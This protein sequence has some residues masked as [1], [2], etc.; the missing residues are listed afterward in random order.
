MEISNKLGL[1]GLNLE[2]CSYQSSDSQATMAGVHSGFQKQILALD[3][4]AG[5]IPCNN[6]S[7]SL[8]D[9]H[10][11]HMNAQTRSFLV[12]WNVCLAN[13]YGQFFGGVF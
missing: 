6:H 11:A 4:V 13:F 10:A 7:L 5:F 12:L 1:D 2:D 8:A 3:T 9:V